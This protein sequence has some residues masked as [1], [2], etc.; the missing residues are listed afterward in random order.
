MIDLNLRFQESYKRLDALCKD[1]FTS[2]DGVSRYIYEMEIANPLYYR[3][4]PNWDRVYKQL[5]HLRWVRNQFAHEV[6]T[7]ESDLC[8]ENDIAWLAEFYDSILTTTDPL[9]QVGRIKRESERRQV[10]TVPSRQIQEPVAPP[11]PATV[12]DAPNREQKEGKTSLWRKL[13][14][15]IKSWFS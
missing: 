10:R 13:K 8:T 12:Q 4:V 9:A 2:T 7:L 3:S 11:P 14:D 6:G 1:I 15:K 5:K